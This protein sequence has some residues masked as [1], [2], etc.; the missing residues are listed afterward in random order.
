MSPTELAVRTQQASRLARIS[1]FSDSQ[2]NLIA[3]TVAPGASRLELCWFLYNAGRLGLEPSL[4]QIYF[5]K[6]D[7][8]GVGEIVIGIGGYRA[9]ADA[10]GVYAGSDEAV[11]E[12]AALPAEAGLPVGAP[13]KATVT[14]HKLVQG[15]LCDFTASVRWEEFYPGE[16]KKG[17]QWRKRP[18]NQM[19]VRAESHA[20][21]KAF[22]RQMQQADMQ[23]EAPREWVEAAEQDSAPDHEAMQR[24]A[25][26]YDEIFGPDDD[27]LVI[28]GS[29]KA[30]EVAKVE[31]EE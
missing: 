5:I 7:A 9:I 12:Y 31:E 19:S 23:R 30:A 21:R 4:D 16:G 27:D 17:E 3:Q 1:G 24:N 15:R 2:I 29:A 18:H 6:Y 8:K 28:E 20:L 14:V 10:S 13:S 26:K 22:P 11:F 25:R